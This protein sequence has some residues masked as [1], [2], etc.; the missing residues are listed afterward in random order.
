MG[1]LV[2]LY[3]ANGCNRRRARGYVPGTI[4]SLHNALL[5]QVTLRGAVA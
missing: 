5:L 1:A 2:I 4:Y 3:Q